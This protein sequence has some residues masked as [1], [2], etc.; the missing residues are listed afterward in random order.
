MFDGLNQY[1]LNFSNIINLL[2]VNFNVDVCSIKPLRSNSHN[3]ACNK[4]N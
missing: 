3:L 4:H 1:V 2:S